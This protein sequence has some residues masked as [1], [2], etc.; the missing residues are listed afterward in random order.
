MLIFIA[1][2]VGFVLLF[3]LIALF[4]ANVSFENSIRLRKQNKPEST[5]SPPLE[6]KDHYA[7]NAYID[8]AFQWFTSA[9]PEDLDILSKDGLVLR[10][11]FFRNPGA[12]S[13]ALVVPGWTDTKETLFCETKMMFD[14]G[15]AVLIVDQRAEGCSEGQF[16][17][18][19]LHEADDV[20]RWLEEIKKW[21]FKHIVLHG[22][23]MG[24]A[25]VMIAAST[26]PEN[27]IACAIEDCGY[28]SMYAQVESLI[29]AKTPWLPG[30]MTAFILFLVDLI[31]KKR[32][33]YSIHDPS[34]LSSLPKCKIPMLFIHGDADTFVPY[35]MLDPLYQAHKGPKERLVVQG[36]KHARALTTNSEQ[37]TLTVK[38]F[39]NKYTQ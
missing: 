21:N 38:A 26:L 23:S 25:T 7:E 10:G 11:S 6:Y 20:L 33:G 35:K 36:A 14:L 8:N 29:Y 13:I 15:L 37:Y 31:V 16:T 39:I 19:G 12:S 32:A 28:T 24:A 34:P 22:R 18:F 27:A 5:Q 4:S 3:V 2:V 1:S 9:R 30:F 17:S